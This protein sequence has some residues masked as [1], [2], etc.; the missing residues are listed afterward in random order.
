L[1]GEHQSAEEIRD[2]PSLI[3]SLS[4][5]ADDTRQ[6]GVAVA[7]TRPCADGIDGAAAI[8]ITRLCDNPA[9]LIE[10]RRVIEFWMEATRS[11]YGRR[12]IGGWSVPGLLSRRRGA[13]SARRGAG[14]GGK[15]AGRGQGAAQKYTQTLARPLYSEPAEVDGSTIGRRRR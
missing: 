2:D 3:V 5:N 10:M 12:R 8:R 4:A 6:A 7:G 1:K 9:A 13:S 14:C 15:G 11:W